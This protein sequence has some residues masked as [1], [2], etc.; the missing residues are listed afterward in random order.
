[1]N[2][3]IVLPTFEKGA[4]RLIKKYESLAAEISSFILKTENEGIQ[5]TNLGNG[6]FKSRLAVKSKSKGKRGGL[7][8][9][10]YSELYFS[11]QNNTIFLVAIYD[12]SDISTMKKSEIER[13]LQEYK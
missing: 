5:G 2:E 9:I 12:K 8:V 7:R 6:I 4:R 13:I 11:L 10:S 1:M 3:I